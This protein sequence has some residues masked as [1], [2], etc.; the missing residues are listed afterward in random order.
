MLTTRE[1]YSKDVLFLF[2]CG[3]CLFYLLGCVTCPIEYTQRTKLPSDEGLVCGRVVVLGENGK[4]LIWGQGDFSNAGM[5]VSVMPE[6][7]KVGIPNWLQS[8][9]LFCWHLRPGRYVITGF[10]WG[11]PMHLE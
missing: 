3:T 2:L 4:P 1:K 9:G 8:D 5:S 6:G 7:G 10:Q 11:N